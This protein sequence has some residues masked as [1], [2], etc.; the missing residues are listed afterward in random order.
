M[1]EAGWGRF[2]LGL[3]RDWGLALGFAI[4]AWAVWMRFFVGGPLTE[5]PAPVFTLPNPAGG[6][7]I[8]LDAL[9]DGPIILNFWFTSCGPCRAEIPELARFHAENPDVPLIGVSIDEM[10]PSRLAQVSKRLGVTW[11]VAHDLDNTVSNAYGV[12][13]YP[14]TIVVRGG[15]IEDVHLGGIDAAGLDRLVR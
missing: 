10:A 5:G 6:S 3:L 13:M 11:P 8:A 7:A 4:V 14:T 15:Q 1:R 9:G 2:V 12:T